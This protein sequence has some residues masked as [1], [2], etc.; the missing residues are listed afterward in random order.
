VTKNFVIGERFMAALK[1]EGLLTEEQYQRTT[2]ITITA[3]A[4]EAVTMNHRTLLRGEQ[5]DELARNLILAE[6]AEEAGK[7]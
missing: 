5:C 4:G 7:P 2:E 6:T 3:K 1:R